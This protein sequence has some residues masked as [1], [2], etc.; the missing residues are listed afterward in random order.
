MIGGMSAASAATVGYPIISFLRIPKSMKPEESIEVPVS[1]ISEDKAFWGEKMGQQIVIIKVDGAPVAFD[2][3]CTHLGCLVRWE[4]TTHT[5][6]CPCHGAIFN[7]HGEPTAGPVNQPL[8]RVEFQIK[9]GVLKV[10]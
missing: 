7:E 10:V 4:P 2:G 5:F 8:K 9:N 3:A 6:K 1:E